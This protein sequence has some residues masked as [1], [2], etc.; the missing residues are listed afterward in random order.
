MIALCSKCYYVDEQDSKNKKFS[1]KD[2]SKR[3][4]YITWQ[5]FKAALNGGID[6][7]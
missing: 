7:A 3:Q 4:N 1:M 2:M 5:R 6:R